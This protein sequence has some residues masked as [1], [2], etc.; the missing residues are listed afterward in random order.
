[1]LTIDRS[2]IRK[3]EFIGFFSDKI[4]L[5]PS[6]VFPTTARFKTRITGDRQEIKL[7]NKHP[8]LK[9]GFISLSLKAQTTEEIGDS[10]VLLGWFKSIRVTQIHKSLPL[11]VGITTNLVFDPDRWFW[12]KVGPLQSYISKL[13]RS[14]LTNTMELKKPI[15]EKWHGELV[16]GYKPK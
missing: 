8:S 11:F 4:D 3:Q 15:H 12:G 10:R 1:M 5:I 14:L 13:G 16:T 2:I 7:S 9:V 6:L